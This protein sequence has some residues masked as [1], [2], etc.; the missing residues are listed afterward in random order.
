MV[1]SQFKHVWIRLLT[2]QI[3]VLS[4]GVLSFAFHIYVWKDLFEDKIQKIV[5]AS[6]CSFNLLVIIFPP[7]AK[8]E[9]HKYKTDFE[10]SG[11]IYYYSHNN[12]CLA[13]SQMPREWIRIIL[14]NDREPQYQQCD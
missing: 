5:I 9:I 11:R 4:G 6:V 10:N 12:Y 8:G 3:L 13:M 1:N 7:T 14:Q 2:S